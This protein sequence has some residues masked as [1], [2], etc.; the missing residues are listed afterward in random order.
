LRETNVESGLILIAVGL[1]GLAVGFNLWGMVKAREYAPLRAWLTRE[2]Y[3][4]D[5]SALSDT[6]RGSFNEVTIDQLDRLRRRGYVAN[7]F[8]GL[9]RVTLK[10]R[11]ALLLHKG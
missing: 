4:G 2:L 10:G 1:I 9:A 7:G 6:A 3:R 8:R 11:L 5:L